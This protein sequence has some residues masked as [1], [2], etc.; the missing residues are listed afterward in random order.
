MFE[1]LLFVVDILALVVNAFLVYY[2]SRLLFIFRGGKKGKSW[3]Y[4]LTGI[5]M[6]TIGSCVFVL[7]H[8][9]GVEGNVIRPLGGV[10]MLI[11]GILMLIGVYLEYKMWSLAK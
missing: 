11:G 3:M 10:F 6:V 7:R 1:S 8:L 5:L 2:T 9:L 4:I